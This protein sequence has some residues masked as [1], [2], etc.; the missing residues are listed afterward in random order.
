V[1]QLGW[2]LCAQI[3]RLVIENH[4]TNSHEFH[5]SDKTFI[6]EIRVNSWRCVF[7]FWTRRQQAAALQAICPLCYCFLTTLS[8]GGCEMLLFNI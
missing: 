1:R 6:R 7:A 5:G 8:G 3:C 4:A 2:A